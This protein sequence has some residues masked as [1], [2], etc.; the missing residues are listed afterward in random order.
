VQTA[1][2]ASNEP[3]LGWVITIFLSDKI[4]PPPDLYV[5]EREFW[6]EA[7][8][9]EHDRKSPATVESTVRAARYDFIT[10]TVTPGTAR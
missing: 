6:A 10:R 3:A 1:L 7:T 4:L 8:L 5:G 2:N 9:D